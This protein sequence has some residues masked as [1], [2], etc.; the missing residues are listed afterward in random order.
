M[1]KFLTSASDELNRFDGTMLIWRQKWRICFNRPQSL[2]L[3]LRVL[4]L[5]K[6]GEGHLLYLGLRNENDFQLK[7]PS[8]RNPDARI[9]L[10]IP[11]ILAR[12]AYE[13]MIFVVI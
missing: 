3:K 2:P 6:S 4:P 13:V 7:M 10:F 8:K 5:V 11:M 12:N 1:K 9:E